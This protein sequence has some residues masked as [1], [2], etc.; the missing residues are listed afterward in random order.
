MFAIESVAS[1][2]LERLDA[3]PFGLIRLARDGT[4]RAYNAAEEQLSG[5]RR[6]DVVG[7]NFFRE[8]APCTAVAEFEGE[9][10]R[11]WG[12][13]GGGRATFAFVF[14]FPG[15]EV[16]VSIAAARDPG[17]DT[18]ALVVKATP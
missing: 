6:A 18:V 9:V 13:V 10:A 3:L 16:M 2:T 8:V 14:R 4:I 7:R 11:L 5:R 12:I 15:G 17:A 1:A